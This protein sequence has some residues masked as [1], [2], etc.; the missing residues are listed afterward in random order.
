MGTLRF[1][2]I[3]RR[4][5]RSLLDITENFCYNRFIVTVG[6]CMSMHLE[7][8][9]LSTTG[10]KKGKQKWA[11]AEHKRKAEQADADWK[12]VLKR[13]G[14]D[15]ASRKQKH[16]PKPESLSSYYSLKV[17]EGRNTTA[18]ISSRNT[19]G[20]YAILKPIPVYTGD[21]MIGIGQLHKSNA[22]PVFRSEDIEDIARMRR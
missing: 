16:V 10:K 1:G 20:G 4:S 21:K 2:R 17:P 6:D 18:R 11:S 5:D 15:S 13:H 14:A 22:V 12:A 8:P 9:W 3:T 19:T 7:G